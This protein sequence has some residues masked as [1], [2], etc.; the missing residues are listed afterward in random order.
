MWKKILALMWL[1]IP[2]WAFLDA[3]LFGFQTFPTYFG[4]CLIE[5]VVFTLGVIFGRMTRI[6]EVKKKNG[7]RR[8]FTWR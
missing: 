1:G 8:F 7:W 4:I 5:M 3:V 6:Q 2:L